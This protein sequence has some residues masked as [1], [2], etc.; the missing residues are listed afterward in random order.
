MRRITLLL[1]I[2][3]P[4]MASSQNYL[5]KKK[6]QV[7]KELQGYLKKNNQLSGAVSET[8]STVV[9]SVKEGSSLP[10]EFA[11]YFDDN[12]KCNREKVTAYCDSCYQKYLGHAL[13]QKKYKWKKINANQYISSFEQKATLELPGDEKEKSFT[14][15]RTEWTKE[16]YKLLTEL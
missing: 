5:D 11:Y 13:G 9:L 3:L 7:K 10:G 14:I 15:L 6:A 16:F 8:D 1:L 2:I 4:Y 12:G